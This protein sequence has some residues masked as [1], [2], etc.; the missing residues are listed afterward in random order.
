MNPHAVRTP[1]WVR[2]NVS[3]SSFVGALDSTL[4][5]LFT[6]TATN[7]RQRGFCLSWLRFCFFLLSPQNGEKQYKCTN[8]HILRSTKY[9]VYDMIPNKGAR[10]LFRSLS[11]GVELLLFVALPTTLP[12][13]LGGTPF[14]QKI[15]W[16]HLDPHSENRLAAQRGRRNIV[17]QYVEPVAAPEKPTTRVCFSVLSRLAFRVGPH[18]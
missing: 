7:L 11:R 8:T 9:G 12:P 6:F 2:V 15:C 10:R 16:S 18:M 14:I 17:V 1:L 3:S 13:T 5:P 4:L